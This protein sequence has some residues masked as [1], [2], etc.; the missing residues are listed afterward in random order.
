MAYHC[1]ILERELVGKFIAKVCRNAVVSCEGTVI[2]WCGGKDD[3]WAEL[4]S[5]L[6]PFDMINLQRI[7]NLISTLLTV[8]TDTTCCAR[9]HRNTIACLKVLDLLTN[10]KHDILARSSAEA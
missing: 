6:A 1:T 10:L 3:V 4:V 9:F 8:F 2:G 7:S 5:F